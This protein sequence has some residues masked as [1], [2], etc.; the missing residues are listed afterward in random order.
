MC[1]LKTISYQDKQVFKE[2]IEKRVK[3]FSERIKFASVKL[4]SIIKDICDGHIDEK[5]LDIPDIFDET[6]IRQMLIGTDSDV[7]E[8]P[9]TND[10]EIRHPELCRK[11]LKRSFG[12]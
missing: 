1:L 3:Q 6:F 7:K 9:Q 8:N 2:A 10:Y 11:D 5:R 12:D 4:V